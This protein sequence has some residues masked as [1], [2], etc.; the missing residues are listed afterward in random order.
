M[1]KILV[2]AY[3]NPLRSDDGIAWQAAEELRRDLP[4]SAHVICVR[5]LT[6]ELAEAASCADSVIFLD[7]STEGSPGTIACQP[8]T[9]EPSSSHFSHHFSPGEILAIC[10]RLY[11]GRPRAFLISM[12]GKSFEHG[13]QLS[14]AA[15]AAIPN[16]LELIQSVVRRSS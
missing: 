1:A 2:I 14:S 11:A 3:G 5:Q 9:A 12:C 8:L 15:V 7:A 10:D 16:A 13:A 6:P 4:D